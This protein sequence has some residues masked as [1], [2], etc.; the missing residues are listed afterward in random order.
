M[1]NKRKMLVSLFFLI[2]FSYSLQ[3]NENK[4][5]KPIPIDQADSLG[6]LLVQTFEGRIQPTHTLA[7]DIIHKISKKSD[8]VTSD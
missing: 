3:A 6:V 2:C 8:V 1:R 5:Y 7:Y 4:V